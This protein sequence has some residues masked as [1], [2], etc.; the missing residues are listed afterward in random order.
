MG[1]HF[2]F[3]TFFFLPN[4]RLS[5]SNRNETKSEKEER[6]FRLFQ[7]IGNNYLTPARR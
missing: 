3:I 4:L 1:A 5:L 6:V 7:L 2:R